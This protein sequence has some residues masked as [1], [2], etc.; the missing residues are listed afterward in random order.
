MIGGAAG[1]TGGSGFWCD[2][3]NETETGDAGVPPEVFLLDDD[4]LFTNE[5]RAFD[6]RWAA[7]L[8]NEVWEDGSSSVPVPAAAPVFFI[9]LV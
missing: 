7:S 4:T 6:A 5:P 9:E 8:R 3:E 1:W 2:V